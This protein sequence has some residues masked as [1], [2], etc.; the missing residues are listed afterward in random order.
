MAQQIFKTPADQAKAMYEVYD[1]VSDKQPS[2]VYDN[3]KAAHDHIRKGNGAGEIRIS[4]PVTVRADQI[5]EKFF[6]VP[7]GTEEADDVL[8]AIQAYYGD[9]KIDYEEA[10]N[11]FTE[12]DVKAAVDYVT[13]KG[14]NKFTYFSDD[15]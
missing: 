12:D 3:E 13:K 11:R 8:F 2:G 5:K 14:Y 6:G 7:A 1:N 4:K 10:K 9:P 15:K